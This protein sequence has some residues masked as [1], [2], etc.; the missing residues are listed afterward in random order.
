M[1]RLFNVSVREVDDFVLTCIDVYVPV[2]TLLLYCNGT[3]LQV[4]E[5][6]SR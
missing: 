3:T 1:L 6:I 4:S 2:L 5:D